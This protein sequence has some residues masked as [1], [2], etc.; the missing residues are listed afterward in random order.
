MSGRN[1]SEALGAVIK[2][3]ALTTIG[4]FSQERD[5]I[6]FTP[7]N[8]WEAFTKESGACSELH[9]SYVELPFAL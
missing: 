2:G 4:V 5:T 6:H 8:K 7:E 1:E 3:Q 9:D